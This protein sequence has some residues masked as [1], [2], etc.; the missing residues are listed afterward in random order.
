MKKLI[1]FATGGMCNRLRPIASA[2]E[3]AKRLNRELLVFWECDFRCPA[4]FK[5]LFKNKL[6]I[7]DAKYMIGLKDVTLYAHPDDIAADARIFGR[8]IL[9]VLYS[10]YGVSN[11]GCNSMIEDD[12]N[13]NIVFISNTFLKQVPMEKNIA[14]LKSLRPVDDIQKRID[15]F[16]E[17]NKLDK[18]VIG[19]SVRGSDINIEIGDYEWQFDKELGKKKKYKLFICSDD[20]EFEDYFVKKYKKKAIRY[21]KENYS[22]KVNDK[23]DTWIDNVTTTKEGIKEGVINL[24][25]LAKTNIKIYY[26][27]S[28]FVHVAK[29]LGE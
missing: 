17:K 13:E 15:D 6:N 26:K 20:K 12:E 7:V 27:E 11:V 25:H 23:L 18:K 4:H 19:C 2:V 16:L 8:N 29:L 21:E 24:Y 3:M 14:W 28:S 22:F 10:K 5:D 9:Q 1:V